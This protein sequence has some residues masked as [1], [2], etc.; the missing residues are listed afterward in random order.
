M[1]HA[2]EFVDVIPFILYSFNSFTSKWKCEFHP[3]SHLIIAQ[4]WTHILGADKKSS[5]VNSFPTIHAVVIA[6]SNTS[7]VSRFQEMLSLQ[8]QI[9]R[10][11]SYIKRMTERVEELR[12]T[13]EKA[14]VAASTI[15][16][17]DNNEIMESEEQV[18]LPVLELKEIMGSSL[19]VNLISTNCS[20]NST[21]SSKIFFV[22]C[23]LISV[24]QEEG[25]E[26]VSA[27]FAH[28][29]SKL[30][31]TIHAQVINWTFAISSSYFRP[32]M[33]IFHVQFHFIS[34]PKRYI[35]QTKQ[36][37]VELFPIIR[38]S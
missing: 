13:K 16:A 26:V 4:F 10:A 7:S 8:E 25:A 33:R 38:V 1:Q 3:I 6:K 22:L 36:N 24:L 20:N 34:S 9:D 12:A 32:C 14:S 2:H 11:A 15:A 27:S 37:L 5:D 31:Y 35:R 18:R 17:N 28:R 23:R 30:F 21:Y 19:Q 29:G